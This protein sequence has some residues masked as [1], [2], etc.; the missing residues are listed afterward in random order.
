MRKFW[1]ILHKDWITEYRAKDLWVAMMAYAVIVVILFGFALNVSRGEVA[2]IFPGVLWMTFLFAGMIAMDKIFGHELAEDTMMGIVLAP[3]DRLAVYL[4]KLASTLSFL[5]LTQLIATPLF[6]VLFTQ[7]WPAHIGRFA[8]ILA[9]GALGIVEVAT[10]LSLVA[11][12][13]PGSGTILTILMAPL[14]IPVLIAGVQATLS[15]MIP[16]QD[17]PG[18]WIHG[19]MAY[20]AI[21]LA[22]PLMLY[23]Y[24]WEA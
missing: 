6:I 14:E 19:L 13:M 18:L 15:V 21:F 23:D 4:G 9:L 7:P 2:R 20:D 17:G 3:G 22:L 24:L 8:G 5:L 1:W 10:L 12:N 16:G 11:V